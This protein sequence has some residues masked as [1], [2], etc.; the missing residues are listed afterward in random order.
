MT[1]EPLSDEAI[2][3][4]VDEV[5]L[6]LVSPTDQRTS[7]ALVVAKASNARRWSNLLIDQERCICLWPPSTGAA[8]LTHLLAATIVRGTNCLN[9]NAAFST[10]S[11]SVAASTS[12]IHVCLAAS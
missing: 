3:E 11:T 10:A 5:F 2:K 9:S 1:F 4:I 6:P 8:V 7:S 12:P